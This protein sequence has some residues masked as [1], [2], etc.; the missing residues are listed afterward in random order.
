MSHQFSALLRIPLLL[1]PSLLPLR[2]S[3][4]ASFTHAP[5]PSSTQSNK[6]NPPVLKGK[7]AI[8]TDAD[9]K[10][11]LDCLLEQQAA[12]N[13]GDNGWKTLVWTAAEESLKG[14]EERSKGSRKTA[15]S[16]RDRFKSLKESFLVVQ[17]LRSLS[18]FGWDD[19]RHLVT[20]TDDVW[21]KYIDWRKKAFPCYD[22]MFALVEGRSATGDNAVSITAMVADDSGDI[23]T[24]R[25]DNEDEASQD[26]DMFPLFP[27]LSPSPPPPP[28]SQCR[29][30]AASDADDTPAPYRMKRG[31]TSGP[32]ALLALAGAV[33]K[34]ANAGTA[35]VGS[36]EMLSGSRLVKVIAALDMDH[37]LTIEE[38]GKALVLF[39]KD[40]SSVDTYMG[41]DSDVLRHAYI[42]AEL[43]SL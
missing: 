34:V 22:L 17:V 42:L 27:P 30:R 31:R 10:A 24:P 21:D 11:L 33:S 32:D 29:K 4:L 37:D 26:M 40:S 12:G 23:G 2:F 1:P 3:P 15:T 18:G 16:C 43:S 14:S 7:K 41:I 25:S 13:Q 28:S 19:Q 6:E 20:A 5:M 8:W 39:R 38:K 9:D 36:S 35:A